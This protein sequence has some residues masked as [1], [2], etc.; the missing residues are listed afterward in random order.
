MICFSAS[1]M[2][3]LWRSG[4]ATTRSRASLKSPVLMTLLLRRAARMAASLTRLARSAPEKPGEVLAMSCRSTV[5]SSGLPLTWTL[6]ISRRPRMSGRSRM[7]WRSK[8]PGRSSG[9]SSTSGRL[10]AAT[11]MTLVFVSKPSISTRIWFSVCSRSSCEPPRPAPRWRPTAAIS[12]TKTMQGEVGLA[13]GGAR[14][15][16]LAGARRPHE[17]HAPRDARAQRGELLRVLEE[18]D[19]LLQLL[20]RFVYAG[21]VGEGHRRPVATE[22]AC[23]ALAEVHRLGVAALGL[24]HEEDQDR[25]EEDERQEADD[26]AKPVAHAAGLLY[27]DLHAVRPADVHAFLTQQVDDAGV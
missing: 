7:T 19:D 2:M 11:T 6:R 24:A 16:R 5:L 14:E 13:R 21:D 4:P 25:P 27:L 10:V 17:Q 18:L 22:R 1:L 12:S 9:G 3:R 20:L 23:L 15:E 26:Q 8:R